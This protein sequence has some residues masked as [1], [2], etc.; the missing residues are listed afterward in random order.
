MRIRMKAAGAVLPLLFLAGIGGTMLSGDWETVSSKQPVKFE[1]GEFAG[2][3]NPADIRGSY[4]LENITDAFGV[5]VEVLARAFGLAG[6]ADPSQTAV[7]E[8][9]AMYGPVEGLEIGTDSMRLFVA[10]YL[11]LP[12]TPAEDTGL[13]RSAFDLA[14]GEGKTAPEVLDSLKGQVV[15]LPSGEAAAPEAAAGE[16]PAAPAVEGTGS[17]GSGETAEAPV[18]T[19]KTTF[20]DLYSWGLSREAVQEVLGSEPGPAGMSVRDYCLEKGVEFQEYKTRLQ[21]LLAAVN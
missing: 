14:A 1:A 3:S 12:Y 17:G 9:E 21:S 11:G 4:T 6:E 20:S 16:A 2:Q 7:K 15:D 13:P 5:P 10:L 18:I 19:G 8:L